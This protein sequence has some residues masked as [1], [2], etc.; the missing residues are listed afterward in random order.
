[1]NLYSL[2]NTILKSKNKFNHE[3]SRSTL[4]NIDN[5][6]MKSIFGFFFKLDFSFV[7]NHQKSVVYLLSSWY[8][9]FTRKN[10]SKASVLKGKKKNT[11]FYPHQLPLQ[12]LFN[13]NCRYN[14]FLDFLFRSFS[15]FDFIDNVIISLY[16]KKMIVLLPVES[17]I[18]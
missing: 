7:N 4:T 14:L 8:V 11:N 17:E 9:I 3:L 15:I 12:K 1:V 18:H 6:P 2:N 13:S 10:S 5:Y 16:L